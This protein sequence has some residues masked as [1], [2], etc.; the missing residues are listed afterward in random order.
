MLRKGASAEVQDVTG[1][2]AM[3][4]AIA[5]GHRALL[6]VVW[7]YSNDGTIRLKENIKYFEI[8]R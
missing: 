2:T 4:L 3:H 8:C 1:T 7:A 6:E 5:G